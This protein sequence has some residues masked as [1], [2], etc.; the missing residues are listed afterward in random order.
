M[1]KMRPRASSVPTPAAS[2]PSVPTPAVEASV[3]KAYN[4]ELAELEF[5]E[6]VSTGEKSAGM[7]G[8]LYD[9]RLI[10]RRNG[11]LVLTAEGRTLLDSIHAHMNGR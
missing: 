9:R 1:K 3:L 4:L 6:E 2:V 11:R 7:T 10:T 5:L 8:T